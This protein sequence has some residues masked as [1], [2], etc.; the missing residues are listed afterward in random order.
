L[1]WAR[2]PVPAADFQFAGATALDSRITYTGQNGTYFNSSG[3]LTAATT[4][5]ARFDYNPSTLIARG[6]L[7]EEARTNSLRNNTGQGVV[8]GAI[9][10]GG[11]PGTNWTVTVNTTTGLTRT[12]VGTSTESGITYTDI[13][14]SGTASGAGSV[15]FFFDQANGVA[16]LTAQTWTLSTY[17]KLQA[18]SWTGMSGPTLGLY[19]YTSAPAFITAQSN[20]YS[21]PSGSGLSTQRISSVITTNGGATT[22]FIRPILKIT[23]ANGAAID[24]TIRIG[25]P[26]LELGAFATSVISTSSAAVTRAADVASITGSNFTSFWNATQGTIVVGYMLEAQNTGDAQAGVQVD[27]TT[28][29]NRLTLRASNPSNNNAFVVVNGG[30]TQAALTGTLSS[31]LVAQKY[32]GAY[33]ANNFAYSQNGLAASSDTSGTIPTVTQMT[34]GN[35]GGSA[36]LNGWISSLSIYSVRLPDATLQA[37]TL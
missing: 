21:L 11:D 37:L 24:F 22:A 31:A 32:V 29:N 33:Q 35:S 23:I 1:H 4:N 25:M 27:D 19:E 34:L 36:Y 9:G 15:D 28:S 13:R 8:A 18:G 5:V 2:F 10:S 17:W 6:L 20:G 12:V 16:A 14:L 26:Q 30:V 3:T 7:I